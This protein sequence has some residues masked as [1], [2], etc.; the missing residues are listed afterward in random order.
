MMEGLKGQYYKMMRERYGVPAK[1]L[2]GKTINQMSA[3]AAK[4]EKKRPSTGIFFKKGR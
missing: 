4:L 2:K 1:Q 3:M